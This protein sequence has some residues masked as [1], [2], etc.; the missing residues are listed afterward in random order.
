MRPLPSGDASMTDIPNG[1]YI[2]FAHEYKMGSIHN[3]AM[4]MNA[5]MLMNKT[6]MFTS[7]WYIYCGESPGA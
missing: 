2:H 1:I 4:G 7:P 5:I 3:W 6:D